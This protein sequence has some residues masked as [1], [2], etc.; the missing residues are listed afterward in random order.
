MNTPPPIPG[1]VETIKKEHIIPTPLWVIRAK[2]MAFWMLLAGLGLLGAIFLSLALVDLLDVGPDF[3][4]TLGFRRFPRLL[5]SSTPIVWTVVFA[6]SVASGIVAFR[7]TKRGYRYRALFVGSLLAL[8]MLTL[9]LIAH[10]LRI[11]DRMDR[12]LEERGVAESFMEPRAARWSSPGDGVISGRII[13]EEN[14]ERIFLLE[15]PSREQW[16]V[17]V[18]DTTRVGRRVLLRTGQHVIVF[19][20]VEEARLFEAVF[21][22][23]LRA[24]NDR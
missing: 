12:A 1:I 8:S 21:I 3:L 5:F 23:P 15:S 4:R 17:R 22:R 6:L 10:V 24:H 14:P 2:N 13:E 16:R 11:D 18:G 20:S 9:A 19:G 7:S